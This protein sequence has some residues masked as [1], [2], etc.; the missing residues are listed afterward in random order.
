MY[1]ITSIILHRM[2][3]PDFRQMCCIV[4]VASGH[5][6]QSSF[7][8]VTMKHSYD[9]SDTILILSTFTPNLKWERKRSKKGGNQ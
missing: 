4:F 3:F 8:R 2:G 1:L 7:M 6:P 5:L 9:H